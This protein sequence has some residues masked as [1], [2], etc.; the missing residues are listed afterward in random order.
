MRQRSL[1]TGIMARRELVNWNPRRTDIET[2]L[3]RAEIDEC[4]LIPTGSNYV[5]LLS[6]RDAEA[7]AG[8]GVYKPRKGEA[9]LWDFPDGTL[10]KRERAAYLVSR[11]LGWDFIPPTIIRDGPYGI[12][13]VQLFIPNDPRVHFFT[14][15]DEHER[16]MRRIALFDAVTNNADRK[17]GHCL[18]DAQGNV[19]GIDHGL[20]F[21]ESNKLRTV[22]WDYRGEPVDQELIADLQGFSIRLAG[23][24]AIRR[25][26]EQLLDRSEFEAFRRRVERMIRKPVYPQPGMHRPVPWPPV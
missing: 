20:A 5:F 21:H 24:S 3:E 6:L 25:E 17:G 11:D 15:R 26:L 10:Y 18:A 2:V 4:G 9:P 1:Y 12:G 16:E 19:W 13:M 8:Y 22:I 14:L 7:G 23:S